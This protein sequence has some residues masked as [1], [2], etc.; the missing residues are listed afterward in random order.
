[1]SQIAHII[2]SKKLRDQLRFWRKYS[3]SPN[4]EVPG[5]LLEQVHELMKSQSETIKAQDHKLADLF[6]RLPEPLKGK[7]AKEWATEW[8]TKDED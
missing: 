3:D 1:M 7:V 2:L 5:V 6:D 4:A 8:E